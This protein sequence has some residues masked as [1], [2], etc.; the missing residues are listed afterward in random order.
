[1]IVL[2]LHMAYIGNLPEFVCGF[3]HDL[4]GRSELAPP[5]FGHQVAT[6]PS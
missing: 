4:S 1:M 3:M 2:N 5:N 6:V